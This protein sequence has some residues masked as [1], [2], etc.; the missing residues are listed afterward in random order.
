MYKDKIYLKENTHYESISNLKKDGF[1]L[2]DLSVID[3]LD[4]PKKMDS[5]FYMVYILSG[6]IDH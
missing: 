4:Y 5:R 3:Y 2:T 1:N 6:T